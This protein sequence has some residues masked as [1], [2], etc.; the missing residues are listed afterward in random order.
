MIK[1]IK[2]NVAYYFDSQEHLDAASKHKNSYD[3]LRFCQVAVDIQTNTVLKCRY[4][5]EDTFD[6]LFGVLND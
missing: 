5:Y 6:K 2:D 1:L 4:S 3:H